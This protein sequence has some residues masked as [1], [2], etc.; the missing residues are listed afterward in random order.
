MTVTVPAPVPVE[1]TAGR[2]PGRANAAASRRNILF[3]ALDVDFRS[4]R[5]EAV[6]VR[7]LA[8]ALGAH[9]HQV[10]MITATPAAS[11]PRLGPGLAHATRPRGRDWS[12]VRFCV[13]LAKEI[14]PDVIYER[15]LSPKI[16]FV[17]SRLLR[18]P[19]VVEVNGVE[20]EA[21]LLGRPPPRWRRLTFPFRRSMYASAAAVIAV[22][23]P[24][25]AIVR[26]RHGLPEARVA[27]VS[28]GADPT[29]FAPI[30]PA[31]ARHHLGW[32][33]TDWIV[34]VGNLVPWQGV[35]VL[36]HAFRHV[37]TRHASVGLAIVGDGLL[38]P[39]LDRLVGELGLGG[40]VVFTGSVAHA[41]VPWYIGA[42]SV[43]AAPFTRERNERIGLSPLKLF[44]YLSC[45]RPVVASDLPGVRETLEAA[46][47]GILVPANAPDALAE[48]LL[49]VL[50]EPEE[51]ERMGAG[52]REYVARVGSWA[53]AAGRIERVLEG[54]VSGAR[55]GGDRT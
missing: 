53:V 40:R 24:L 36:I 15:R 35:E 23:S 42:A 5:G 38:R 32:S 13:R 51:A 21:A 27:V 9:G 8:G 18:I 10:T 37:T 39:A 55:P 19:F 54:V 52:G 22:S 11:V 12:Q 43:C 25:A 7:E 3:L 6:H 33:Q 1:P 28:N 49:R 34:F 46:G 2:E 20:E 14:Q 17:L 47:A 48:A 16:S 44:E 30:N 4:E 45:A 31:E 50:V 29:R 41:D 26:E